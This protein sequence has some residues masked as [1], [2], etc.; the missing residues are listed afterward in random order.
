MDTFINVINPADGAVVGRV[1]AES[2]EDVRVKVDCLRAHQKE[3]ESIGARGR[4]DWLL[5]YQDWILDNARHIADVL[6]SETG[7]TRADAVV[8]AP[9]TSR[10]RCM[11]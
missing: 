6:Q 9:S 3:W 5:I 4:K 10:R 1:P 8:E 11:A 2:A 7:K